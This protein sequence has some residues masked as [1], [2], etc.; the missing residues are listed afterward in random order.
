MPEAPSTDPTRPAQDAATR[1]APGDVAAAPDAG[2]FRGTATAPPP[3]PRPT[4]WLAI[5]VPWVIAVLALAATG[6]ST[7]QWQQLAAQEGRADSARAA[8]L[9]FVED[10]TNWDAADGLDDEITALREQGTGPFLDEINAVFGGDQLTRQLQEA[11]VSATSEV[12]EA[13][14]QDLGNGTAEIFVVVSVT[15]QTPEAGDD[16]QPVV[17]PAQV[18]LEERGDGW[19]VRQVTVPNAGQI[20]QLMA[21]P[22]A[23]DP[24]STTEG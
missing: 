7:W 23:P 6:F 21:P 8:A 19:L 13:F 17:F 11:E 3:G 18:V 24:E 12:E 16:P 14:V 10:L 9:T 20:S 15:Y 22:A 5:V 1:D 4:R 2:A